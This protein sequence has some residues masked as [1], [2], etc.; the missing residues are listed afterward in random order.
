MASNN[1]SRTGS[2]GRTSAAIV[3]D[4]EEEILRFLDNAVLE[5]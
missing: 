2:L 3:P 5:D 4:N 1:G